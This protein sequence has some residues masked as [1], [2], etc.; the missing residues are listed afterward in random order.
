[1][2]D[3]RVARGSDFGIKRRDPSAPIKQFETHHSYF[4]PMRYVN[5]FLTFLGTTNGS[6]RWYLWWS[7]MFGNLTIFAAAILFYRKH[8]CHV[9]RCLRLGSHVAVDQNGVEHVVC[10]RHH[11]DLGA[12]HQLHPDQLVS[13]D[14]RSPGTQPATP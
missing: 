9:H 13:G 12:H 2:R 6:G 8:D 10:R 11:P 1:M 14:R 3:R 4:A 5:D 7:G